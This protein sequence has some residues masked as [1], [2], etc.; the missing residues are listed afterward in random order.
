MKELIS[1][2]GTTLVGVCVAAVVV[3]IIWVIV[4]NLEIL[5]QLN[6]KALI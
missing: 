3:G 1:E 6:I 4:D 2:Y 5:N